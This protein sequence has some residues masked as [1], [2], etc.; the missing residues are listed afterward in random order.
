[1]YICQKKEMNFQQLGVNTNL[2]KSISALSIVQ[3]T[4]IQQQVIPQLLKNNTHFVAQAQTGTG[5]TLAFSIPIIQRIETDKKRIQALIICPT[6][7]LCQQTTK[8]I[9]KYTKHFRQVFVEAA[10]GGKPIE[11]QIAR[12]RKP[13]HILVATPGRLNELIEKKAVDLSGIHQFVLDEADEILEMGFK[14]DIERALKQTNDYRKIWMFSATIP[15]SL[16]EIINAY[17][18]KG[19]PTIRLTQKEVINPHIEHQFLKCDKEEK[20][21]MA[22][23]FLKSMG[24][25]R[26]IIFCRTKGDTQ[27]L[28]KQLLAKNFSCE[29]LHGDL[30]QIER[31]KVMRAFKNKKTQLL[32]STDMAARGID[33]ENLSYVLHYNLPDQPAFYTHRSGRTARAGKK[34][35]SLSFVTAQDMRKF[36]FIQENLSIQFIQIR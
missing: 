3:P 18:G 21:Q 14:K 36:K 12:L 8:A 16:Q 30:T 27:L 2:L 33:V 34:G 1:M 17:M 20:P 11:Q 10:Y 23:E 32:I 6:R 25:A 13:T 15:H 24:N 22:I 19:V 31:D 4:E 28:C 29:A 26:G 9:F 7:E 5:K 35:I